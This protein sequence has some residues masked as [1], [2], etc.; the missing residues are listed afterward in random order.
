MALSSMTGFARSEGGNDHARWHWEVRSVN[1]R[2]LDVRLRLP[3]GHDAL[4]QPA[5]AA[6]AAHLVRGNVSANLNVRYQT[7][8][9]TV[10]INPDNLAAVIT[11]ARRIAE[12]TGDAAVSADA[13]LNARGVLES[14]EPA[15]DE[16]LTPEHQSAILETLQHTLAALVEA[17]RHE[18]A[19]LETTLRRQVD[20]IE[21]QTAAAHAHPSRN[22]E[23][24]RDRLAENL[25]RLRDVS[26]MQL[27]PDRLHQEA[28]LLATKADIAEEIDRLY[29]H[30]TTARQ[31]IGQG[32][33][34]GRKLDF[35]VQ[36]FNREANTLCS[37]ANHIEI[38]RIGLDMK[39]TIDQLR[40]QVQNVE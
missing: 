35:L 22:P 13:I 3:A 1:G 10:S 7:A 18:G 37:K 28:M 39:A 6:I 4:D 16:L 34:A 31:L 8:A 25:K 26:D 27:D 9:A 23:A 20:D 40:E 11:A 19:Q 36:E 21:A 5:R 30:V 12:Q 33:P 14:V 17:R 15:L 32:S 38:T 24:I 2:G 29:A